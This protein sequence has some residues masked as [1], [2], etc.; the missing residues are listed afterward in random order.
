MK[1]KKIQSERQ[2]LRYYLIYLS[3]TDLGNIIFVNVF[4]SPVPIFVYKYPETT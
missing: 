3:S 4:E 1:K 2:L